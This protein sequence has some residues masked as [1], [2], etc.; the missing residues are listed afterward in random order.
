[1]DEIILKGRLDGRQRNK[2]KGL[3]D[4][5]YSPSELAEELGFDKEQVYAVY[6]PS[7]CPHER[8]QRKH[9]LINGKEFSDWYIKIYAKVNLLPNQSFCKSCKK[10]V[11]IYKPKEHYKKG[12]TYILS[13][14]PNC[15]RNLTKIIS[16][17]RVTDD[18]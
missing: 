7:G 8:D 15:G 12:L 6:I 1:M 13:E 9:I 16:Y 18:Y 2:L 11:E 5:M 17:I 14:C 3:F 10:G 4:M